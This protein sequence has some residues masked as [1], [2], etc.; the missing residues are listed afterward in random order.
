MVGIGIAP[1][2]YSYEL[3][4]KSKAYAVNV[5]DEKL[6]EAVRI[7]GEN[8]GRDTDKFKLA[9]LTATPAS[10]ITARLF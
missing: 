7:C 4:Q 10:K 8:S 3:I 5:V 2:R 6:I 1:S 9:K